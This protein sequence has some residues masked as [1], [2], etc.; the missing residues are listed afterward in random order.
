M[1]EHLKGK[2]LY[3]SP[4][5][6]LVFG[7]AAGLAHYLQV[8][9]VFIRLILVALAFLSGW[10]PMLLLY[11]VAVVLVPVDPSQDT[12]DATQEPKDVTPASAEQPLQEEKPSEAEKMDSEQNM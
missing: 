7:I 9:V 12:V 3:R 6:A 5:D 8:D 10:W 1:F 4:R 2:K 11:V